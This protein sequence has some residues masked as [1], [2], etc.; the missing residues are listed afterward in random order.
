MVVAYVLI[1]AIG[2][3][4]GFAGALVLGLSF[5]TALL[6]YPSGGAVLVVAAALWRSAQ[7]WSLPDGDQ[8]MQ[9]VELSRRGGHERIA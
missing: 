4:L 6:M 9:A 1:G 2:G 5:W 7:D 8:E 3:F